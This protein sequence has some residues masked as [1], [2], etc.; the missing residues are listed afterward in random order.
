MTSARQIFSKLGVPTFLID[1]CVQYAFFLPQTS[2]PDA[3]GVQ[4][5]VKALQTGLRKKGYATGVS[6]VFGPPEASAM[7]QISPPTDSWKSKTWLE[8]AQAVLLARPKAKQMGYFTA[9]GAGLS[10]LGD[11]EGIFSKLISAIQSV[12]NTTL[13]WG[14]G[15][16]NKSN[17]APADAATK[18][19]F[20]NLQHQVNRLMRGKSTIK[21]DGILGTGTLTALASVGYSW[22]AGGVADC[23]LVAKQAGTLAATLRQKADSLGLPDSVPVTAAPPPASYPPTDVPAGPI[24]VSIPPGASDFMGQVK[25]YLPY[26]AMG[27]GGFWLFMKWRKRA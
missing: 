14:Y 23:G 10:G 17:C 24:N 21:E 9:G 11:D 12:E 6:G 7:N 4:Q 27:L 22:S 3:Q 25:T 16:K 19:V 26:A 15:A 2:D 18:K 13:K 20:A 1:L 5:I 8:L